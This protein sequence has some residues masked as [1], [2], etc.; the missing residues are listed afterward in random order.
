MPSVAYSSVDDFLA[1]YTS[2]P[3]AASGGVQY[4][5]KADIGSYFG[6]AADIGN[7]AAYIHGHGDTLAMDIACTGAQ[8]A[9]APIPALNNLVPG[10]DDPFT[11]QRFVVSDG[12]ILAD[13]AHFVAIANNSFYFAPGCH[14]VVSDT[15][16]NIAWLQFHYSPFILQGT[17][18]RGATIAW[19]I[20]DTS[21][22]LQAL[23]ATAIH[24][25][26]ENGLT[27]IDVTDDQVE[28]SLSQYR[29]MA[30]IT[31]ADEDRHVVRGTDEDDTCTAGMQ[32]TGFHGGRG[33]DRLELGSGGGE[34]WGGRGRDIL[35]GGEGTD[36][37]TFA[38]HGQSALGI[39]DADVIRNFGKGD[40][41][42]LAFLDGL[43]G[44][45]ALHWIGEGEF[46]STA[47]EVR[48]E[49]LDGGLAI[50]VDSDGDGKAD[51]SIAFRG[52]VDLDTADFIA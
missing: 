43:D 3:D 13:G 44:R 29:A 49:A 41:V 6:R 52:D 38:R 8:F 11:I 16:A 48:F 45:P 50:R 1:G 21:T 18:A 15:A 17:I 46:S 25:L 31:F 22:Q 7:A 35:T 9:A 34:L 23:S 47:G 27:S 40:V 26:L 51:F 32:W 12:Q 24:D 4:Y 10:A 30:G 36:E 37:F 42:R 14:I 39:E 28:M 19:H 33:D 20:A 5:V 2:N